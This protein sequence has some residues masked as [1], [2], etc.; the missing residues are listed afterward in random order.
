[1]EKNLNSKVI[2]YGADRDMAKLFAEAQ[3]LKKMGITNTRVMIMT[4]EEKRLMPA[5]LYT[6][7]DTFCT[8]YELIDKIEVPVDYSLPAVRKYVFDSTEGLPLRERLIAIMNWEKYYYTNPKHKG[9]HFF[10][11]DTIMSIIPEEKEGPKL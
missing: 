10:D 1:M 6:D 5:G 11:F 7:L 4:E 2:V 8:C 9:T 3:E